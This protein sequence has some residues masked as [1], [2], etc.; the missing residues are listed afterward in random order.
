MVLLNGLVGG[1]V[2]PDLV[3]VVS[4]LIEKNGGLAGIINHLQQHGLG[5]AV[6][7]WIRPGHNLPMS[8]DQVHEVFGSSTLIELSVRLGLSP[9]T[10]ARQVAE[11]L[12]LAI[13]YLTPPGS[14]P[15]TSR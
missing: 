14:M 15:A 1:A 7:S 10:L 11:L 2:G 4:A 8:S 12:P 3:S 6:R 9:Q 13:D 5:T